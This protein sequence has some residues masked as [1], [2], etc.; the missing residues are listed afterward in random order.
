[1]QIT[2]SVCNSSEGAR[3]LCTNTLLAHIKSEAQYDTLLPPTP[4]WI[5]TGKRRC[6]KICQTVLLPSS[7]TVC[8]S[9]L[10]PNKH[11]WHFIAQLTTSASL[12]HPD[13]IPLCPFFLLSYVCFPLTCIC[14]HIIHLI[15]LP[16]DTVGWRDAKGN[17]GFFQSWK[18]YLILIQ[19]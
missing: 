1:M 10:L 7:D 6:W 12:I 19:V 4:R 9:V 13:C 17:L 16:R 11:L 15:Q 18:I 14:V 3:D 2:T 8:M 5:C